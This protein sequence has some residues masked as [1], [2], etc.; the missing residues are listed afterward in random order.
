MDYAMW[1]K[2]AGRKG[3]ACV[4][5]LVE[6]LGFVPDAWQARVLESGARRGILNCA[7]QCGKS[8]VTAVMAVEQAYTQ[9]ESLTLVVSPSARQ[10]G[11]FLRKAAQFAKKLGVS[12]KGDGDNEMSLP[13]VVTSKPAIGGHLKTGH[14]SGRTQGMKLFYTSTARS[15]KLHSQSCSDPQ[16]SDPTNGRERGAFGFAFKG[17]F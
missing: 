4:A 6:R 2:R 15:G 1:E 12:R 8:T 5:T 14:R 13:S 11:E 17:R 7:R 9:A 3:A 16:R 10:S